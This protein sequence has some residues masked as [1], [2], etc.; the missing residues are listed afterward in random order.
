MVDLEFKSL[1]ASLGRAINWDVQGDVLRPPKFVDRWRILLWATPSRITLR[2]SQTRSFS[3]A[4][5]SPSLKMVS[6]S[7]TVSFIGI[8][9]SSPLVLHFLCNTRTSL[10][11]SHVFCF[12]YINHELLPKEAF[13]ASFLPVYVEEWVLDSS[14][15]FMYTDEHDVYPF[16]HLKHAGWYLDY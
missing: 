1:E 11:F 8:S 6:R 10:I 4:R 13:S 2:R 16:A 7:F 3:R 9:S 5:T 12:R 14:P 15:H